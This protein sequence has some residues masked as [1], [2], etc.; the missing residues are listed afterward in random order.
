MYHCCYY[1]D[2]YCQLVSHLSYTFT[3]Y[4]T[5]MHLIGNLSYL[6]LTTHQRGYTALL[7]AARHG[8]AKVATLLLE[9]GANTDY[10]RKVSYYGCIECVVDDND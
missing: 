8:H 9:L 3:S 6:S 7:R 5:S 1:R 10:A 2:G 4:A